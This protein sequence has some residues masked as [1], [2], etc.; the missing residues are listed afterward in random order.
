MIGGG[1]APSRETATRGGHI[2]LLLLAQRRR[3]EEDAV[4]VVIEV[5]GVLGAVEELSLLH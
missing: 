3:G 5:V 2:P 4:V 1:D